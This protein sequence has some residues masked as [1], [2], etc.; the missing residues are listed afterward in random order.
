MSVMHMSEQ[1][2]GMSFGESERR[3]ESRSWMSPLPK[4]GLEMSKEIR[5]GFF[6]F[7]TCGGSCPRTWGVAL[8]RRVEKRMSSGPAAA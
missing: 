6:V 4:D 1:I 7:L 8:T 3:T 5:H 2:L